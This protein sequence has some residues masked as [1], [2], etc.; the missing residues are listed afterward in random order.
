MTCIKKTYDK[1]TAVTVVNA[2]AKRHNGKKLRPYQCPACKAWHL[3]SHEH[4]SGPKLSTGN[5]F[6]K[7]F[8]EKSAK[9]SARAQA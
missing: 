4:W 7:H 1:K 5:G 8:Y 2:L 9:P 3:T 6:K